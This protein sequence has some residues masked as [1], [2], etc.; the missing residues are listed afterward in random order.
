MEDRL[1]YAG[2]SMGLAVAADYIESL[3]SDEDDE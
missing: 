3:K 1:Y 2:Q